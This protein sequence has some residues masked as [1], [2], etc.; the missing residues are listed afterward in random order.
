MSGTGDYTH[1]FDGA[2]AILRRLRGPDGCPWDRR[3]T[4]DDL[5]AQFLEECYELV[6]AIDNGDVA[7]VVRT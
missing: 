4:R 5:K 7:G 6:E 1:D 2:L 3:Q